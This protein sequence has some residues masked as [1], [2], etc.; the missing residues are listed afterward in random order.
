MLAPNVKPHG[1]YKLLARP[2]AFDPV[3]EPMRIA[4]RGQR[5]IDS[6][7][8]Q[9][10]ECGENPLLRVR[11]VFDNPRA[12]YRIELEVPELHYQRITLLDSDALEELLALDEVRSLLSEA[13]AS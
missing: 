1:T 5:I 9:I 11:Q 13:V 10:L 3:L 2:R 12:I 6:L 4:G 7:R 8:H